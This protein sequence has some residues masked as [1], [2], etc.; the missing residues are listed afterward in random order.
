P[1]ATYRARLEAEGTLAP[2][3]AAE[4]VRCIGGWVEEAVR[5]ARSSPFPPPEMLMQHVTPR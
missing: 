2:G 1:V 5:F 4:L 3:A